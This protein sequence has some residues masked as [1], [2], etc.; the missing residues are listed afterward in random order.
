MLAVKSTIWCLNDRI[1]VTLWRSRSAI[2]SIIKC[3]A[4]S[5]SA[6][7]VSARSV[8]QMSWQRA[9]GRSHSV[10]RCN[11][12][13]LYA[14][15]VVDTQTSLARGVGVAAATILAVADRDKMHRSTAVGRRR[16]LIQEVSQRSP[17]AIRIVPKLQQQYRTIMRW[18]LWLLYNEFCP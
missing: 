18:W 2:R 9:V 10:S 3:R 4:I 17:V 7:I 14:D 6:A 11:S 5:H 12:G 15:I 8:A 13:S 16:Q 1:V